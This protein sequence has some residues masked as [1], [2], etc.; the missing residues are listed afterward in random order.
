[1]QRLA[2]SETETL[3]P[4]THSLTYPF[5]HLPSP[6]HSLITVESLSQTGREKLLALSSKNTSVQPGEVMS[7]DLK[8]VLSTGPNGYTPSLQVTAIA[9][10]AHPG[11]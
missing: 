5:T 9:Y 11:R 2:P 6:P 1:M 10:K 7:R 4:L 8:V 3:A